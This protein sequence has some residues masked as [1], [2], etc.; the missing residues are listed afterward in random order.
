MAS[1][2]KRGRTWTANVFLI[3]GDTKKRK[4]KSG[5]TT[6]SE[7]NKWAIG[8][9]NQKIN[10]VLTT[11]DGII[12]DMFNDWYQVFKEPQLETKSK[13]WYMTTHRVISDYWPN[14]KI[15]EVDS[16]LFQELINDYGSKHVKSSVAHI[17][18]MISAFVRYAVDEDYINKDF[19]RNIKTFSSVE[20]K[21]KELKFLEEAELEKLI[22]RVK[23]SDAT[24]S[25]MILIAIY[26]GARYSEVAGLT[27]Q[28]F[29]FENNTISINKSWQAEDREFKATKTKS[30]NRTVDMP[31][32]IMKL[33]NG[34]T[35][36]ERFA[37]E[38][39]TTGLPPTNNAANKQLRRYLEMDSSKLI[40][41]H[42][43]RHTHASFLLSKDIAIQYV[44]E[45]LGHAD[46]N[47]TLSVYAH[48]LDKKRNIETSKA[49]TELNKL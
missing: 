11:K 20:N 31:K 16:K 43:L 48:L 30:S 44:S 9:E 26:S 2:Y 35:P 4:T 12:A 3:A 7:A 32:D 34:W 36:G 27:I 15:S 38:I 22:S 46:V 41:F 45:R 18:N 42:G 37:F 21:S 17:K 40:T 29:N 10:N 14:K 24:T 49:L 33:A 23:N 1:I 28:D 8:I 6:K 25:H 19:T 47:I 13:T 5:F 39:T